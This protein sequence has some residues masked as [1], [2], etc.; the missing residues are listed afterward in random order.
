MDETSDYSALYL[1]TNVFFER[2]GLFRPL[3][4]L[5]TAPA[6]AGLSRK[7]SLHTII[8]LKRFW[9]ITAENPLS[10]KQTQA[11]NQDLMERL[12][13]DLV[14]QAISHEAV[15]CKSHDG[16]WQEN[17]FAVPRQAHLKND[18]LEK[19]IIALAGKY[20]Q[21]SAFSFYGTTMQILPVLRPDIRGQTRYFIHAVQTDH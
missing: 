7:R 16:L 2:E 12:G 20:L 17:S 5:S 8:P 10:Q 11:Q 21:N 18:E 9:I 3:T 15:T 19:L 1:K 13:K 4:V 14:H 6:L